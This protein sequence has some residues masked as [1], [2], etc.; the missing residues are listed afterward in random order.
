[1]A[2]SPLADSLPFL[3]AQAHR[4]VHGDLDAVLRR[5]GLPVEQWRILTILG[6]GDGRT[7]GALAAEV[8]MNM[9]ALS[10][11]VDRMVT[12]ALVHRKSDPEDNRRVRVYVTEFGLELLARCGSEVRE[13]E[14]SMSRQLGDWE[15]ERL[16]RLLRTLL[17]QDSAGH[18]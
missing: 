2:Q 5:E 15:T 1:M 11:T 16:C 7:M 12:R 13:F 9:S 8:G 3:L 4:R 6:D 17:D 18:A 14:R 10:K